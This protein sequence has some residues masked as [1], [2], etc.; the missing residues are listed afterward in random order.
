[1]RS[2]SRCCPE[3]PTVPPFPFSSQLV[4]YTRSWNWRH[5]KASL[6]PRGSLCFLFLHCVLQ[7]SDRRP[8]D[9][10]ALSW[11]RRE[12]TQNVRETAVPSQDS[13]PHATSLNFGLKGHPTLC[14]PVP[15]RSWLDIGL[16]KPHTPPSPTSVR[17]TRPTG[18]TVGL[19]VLI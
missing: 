11:W 3:F 14:L 19:G 15:C 6:R 18:P 2:R 7:A 8:L 16:C 10:M 12:N 9:D 4:C 17:N 5:G 13:H 1:M